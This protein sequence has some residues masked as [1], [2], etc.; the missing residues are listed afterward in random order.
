MQALTLFNQNFAVAE[1]LIQLYELFHGLRQ[2]DLKEDLRF[3]VCSLLGAHQHA[4]IRPSMNDRVLVVAQAAAR[5]PESLTMAGGLNFLLRE[6]VVV[7]CTALES[8]F[9]DALRENVLTV[10]Q[11]RKTRADESLRKLTFTLGDY[12]SIQQ[13]DD[14]D[15]RLKQIILKNFERQTLYDAASLE[16]IAQILTIR[17]FWEEIERI[18]GNRAGDFK[19]TLGELIQ[20]R[21]QI[22]HRADRPEEGEEADP[23]GLRP[24]TLAWTNH[25]IQNAKTIVTASAELIEKTINGLEADIQANKEQEEAQKLIKQMKSEVSG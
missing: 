10:V 25:R 12:V 4:A 22:A 11:A 24:I 23:F 20:R 7:A 21:N 17:N 9:G 3:A 14:Q 15:Y 16:R 5:V 18:T 8:F 2:V 13:Y 6:A 1:S 19:R